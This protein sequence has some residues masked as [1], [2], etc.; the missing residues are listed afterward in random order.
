MNNLTVFV[1]D[2]IGFFVKSD[3]PKMLQF[4]HC[5]LPSFSSDA[6]DMHSVGEKEISFVRT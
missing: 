3:W 1:I 4:S 6:V 5:V 2:Q